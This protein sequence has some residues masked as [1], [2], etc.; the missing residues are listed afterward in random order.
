MREEYKKILKEKFN[1]ELIAIK[2]KYN[3]TGTEMAE[4]LQMVYRSY[5]DLD[6]GKHMASTLSFVIFV[7]EFC[8]DK[9]KFFDELDIPVD[10]NISEKIKDK[11][12]KIQEDEMRGYL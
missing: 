1:K 11:I 8:R 12:K 5:S 3:L 4:C 9:N 7:K 2:E 10:E 6:A